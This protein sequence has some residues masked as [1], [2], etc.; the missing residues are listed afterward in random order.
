MDDICD[1]GR[2]LAVLSE[3]LQLAG[4]AEV[5]SAVLIY[6]KALS[7]MHEPRWKGFVYDGP[8]W[9]VGYGMEDSGRWRNMT[10]VYR[11]RG[12]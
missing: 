10:S 12:S 3:K 2:T 4:A 1:S 6:R 11:I 8:E 9:F 5:V 7:V